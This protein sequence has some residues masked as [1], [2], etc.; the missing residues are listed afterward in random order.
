M[1]KNNLPSFPSLM[2]TGKTCIV[3]VGP[4]SIGK[5]AFAIQVAQ[6]F[7]TQIIS[8][9]S[10][11]CFKEL[12]IGVAKPSLQELNAVPHHFINSHSIH[13][14]VNAGVFE[15]YALQKVEEIFSTNDIAVVVGGTGLYVKTFCQGIDNIPIIPMEIR[16]Q[17]N[18]GYTQNGIEWLQQQIELL[19]PQYFAK[20]EIQNPQRLMRALEVVQFTGQSIINFQQQQKHQRDFKIVKIGLQMPREDLYN[21]INS[22]VDSMLQDGLLKEVKNLLPH[23]NLNALQ[24]V[25]YTELFDYFDNKISLDRAIEGIKQNTRHY[26]KRQITWFKKDGDI[27]WLN[28]TTYP[29]HQLSDLLNILG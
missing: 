6:H 27:N 23:K 13:N 7:N 1:I 20:G 18:E 24:T 5:T 12:T 9:D 15:K 14:E 16:N 2:D 17:I 11:Q 28:A 29:S 25:G 21:R 22:R 3:L 10:R 4:T 26:A 19:D 8:A